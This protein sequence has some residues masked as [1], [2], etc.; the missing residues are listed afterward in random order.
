MIPDQL[1]NTTQPSKKDSSQV[2]GRP[3]IWNLRA[4]AN[5]L[6][7][8]ELSPWN[9]WTRRITKWAKSAAGPSGIQIGF[10]RPLDPTKYKLGHDRPLDPKE[11]KWGPDRRLDPAE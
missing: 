7:F 10:D 5:E 6:F 8:W 4:R 1:S 9:R 3:N 2:L 11:Y